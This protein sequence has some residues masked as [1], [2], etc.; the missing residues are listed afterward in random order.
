MSSTST[1]T[2]NILKGHRRPPHW[3]LLSSSHL[4]HLSVG[5]NLVLV[6]VYSKE[7]QAGNVALAGPQLPHKHGEP[8][9]GLLL[10]L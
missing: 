4:S 5:R 9:Q 8:H 10:P 3:P 2:W 1:A 7:P 6:K